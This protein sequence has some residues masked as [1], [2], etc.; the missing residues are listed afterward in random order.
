MADQNAAS[1]PTTVPHFDLAHLTPQ[2]QAFI[3]QRTPLRFHTYTPVDTPSA[4]DPRPHLEPYLP[5]GSPTSSSTSTLSLILTPPRPEDA[6]ALVSTLNHPHV[7]PQLVGPPYPYSDELAREFIQLKRRDTRAVLERL[8]ARA[9]REL[10]RDGS[11]EEVDAA[12]EERDGGEPDD[13]AAPWLDKLPLC[14]IR[15]ADT[16]E[17]V[18]DLGVPRWQFEDVGDGEERDRLVSANEA[19]TASDPSA[20]WSFGFYLRPSFHGQGIMAHVLRSVL[21]S[22]LFSYLGVDEVRGS[23]FADNVASIKTQEKCGLRRYGGYE[24][25]VS[26]SRGGGVRS[27]V[28]LKVTRDDFQRL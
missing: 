15:R 22:Y 3:A 2:E 5:L 21:D 20:L 24:H 17:Y 4:T 25:A 10:R 26:E 1:T 6:G 13:E 27:I 23:A 19:K 7:A 12:P 16:G 11:G 9:R 18:G 28:V 14:A 8:A